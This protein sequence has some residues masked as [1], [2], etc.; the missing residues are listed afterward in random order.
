MVEECM[1][2]GQS[3]E[4]VL[5]ANEV[6]REVRGKAPRGALPQAIAAL[7]ALYNEDLLDVRGEEDPVR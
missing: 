3:Y 5:A 7:Q 2:Q 6:R 1:R 4:Q